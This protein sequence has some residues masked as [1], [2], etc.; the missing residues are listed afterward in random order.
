M[1]A[2]AEKIDLLNPQTLIWTGDRGKKKHRR[3]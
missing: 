3:D 1:R 2:K